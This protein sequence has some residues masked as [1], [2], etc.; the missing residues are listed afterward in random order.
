[1]NKEINA[2]S[3]VKNAVDDL[4]ATDKRYLKGKWNLL[5]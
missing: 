5:V 3:H 2:P 1:M 4:N